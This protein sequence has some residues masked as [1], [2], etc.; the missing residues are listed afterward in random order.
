MLT[1]TKMYLLKLC[2]TDDGFGRSWIALR[3]WSNICGGSI[4]TVKDGDSV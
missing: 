4:T 3:I 1:T 2:T